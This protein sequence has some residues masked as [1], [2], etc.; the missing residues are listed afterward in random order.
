MHTCVQRY[1]MSGKVMTL[2]LL[3]LLSNEY[4][5]GLLVCTKVKA[6]RCEISQKIKYEIIISKLF[7]W[8]LTP[9]LPSM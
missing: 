7:V 2:F 3:A 9:P 8:Y 5:I 1:C 6:E 4:S